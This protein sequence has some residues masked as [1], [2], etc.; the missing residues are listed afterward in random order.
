MK[1]RYPEFAII[2]AAKVQSFLIDSKRKLKYYPVSM[3]IL[4]IVPLKNSIKLTSINAQIK[5]GIFRMSKMV[6]NFSNCESFPGFR[7]NLYIINM[8]IK[9]GTNKML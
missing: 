1:L 2:L 4:K 8:P 3:H 6:I 7:N 9:F 5:R